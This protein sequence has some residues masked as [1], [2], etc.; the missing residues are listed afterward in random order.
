MLNHITRVHLMGI[1][2][3]G[4]SALSV[5]LKAKGLEVSGCD[6]KSPHYDLGTI[7]CE[8]PHS[9]KHI[10]EYAPE[11]LILSSAVSRENPEVICALENGVKI[12]SRAQALSYMFN[13]SYGIGIAGTH[14]KTTTTSMTGLIFL[15]AGLNPTIYVGANVPDIGTNAISGSGPNFI[16][17]LDESDG[18]FELFTPNIAIIT[19]A[20][21]DH[22]DHYPTREEGIRAF[23]RFADGRKEG[24]TLILCGEDEGASHVFE[25]CDKSRG[26]ILRYGFGNSWDWGAY[27]ITRNHGGGISCKVS[28][29]GHEMG[30]LTLTVSG[31]HNILNAL[32]AISAADI[33]GIDFATSAEILRDFHGS[34]RRM[35]VKGVT[36]NDILVM[37][38]YAHHPSEIRATL[39]AVRG[40]YPERRIVV[41]Y[42]PH[43]FTRTA[44]FAED[45]ANALSCAD[46][47]YILPVYSAGEKEGPHS[48][49]EE[50]VRLSNGKITAVKFDDADGVLKS[51]LS[52]GDLLLTMGAGDV[53]IEG[54]KFLS[55]NLGYNSRNLS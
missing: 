10:A 27:D 50:V 20:D 25:N 42:Q 6:L 30:T 18:T 4:M 28:H 2:G 32:G 13:R 44:M 31:E 5:L 51:E 35:Q 48:S 45:I 26:E 41:L 54:E 55:G 24:G 37:D 34:E 39:E 12:L 53:Y 16:A 49:S 15:K 23:I 11:A 17:E 19:N 22:V 43:R 9:P 33:C 14:G 40:I 7:P 29:K 38:D 1:G 46:K 8:I 36:S 52:R 21:W 3:S 47:A